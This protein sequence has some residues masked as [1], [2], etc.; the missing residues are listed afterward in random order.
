MFLKRCA[1]IHKGKTY[2]SW[3]IV[4]AYREKGKIKHRYMMNVSRFTSSQRKRIV[5]LLIRSG[6]N[7]NIQNNDGITPLHIT[8]EINNLSIADLLIVG[9][10]MVNIRDSMSKTPLVYAID[11]ESH[12]LTKF[13]KQH[14]GIK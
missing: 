2:Q 1:R 7:T 6:A 3:W 5:K 12:E 14:G 9:G 13:I 8:A 11:N 10:A 4:E